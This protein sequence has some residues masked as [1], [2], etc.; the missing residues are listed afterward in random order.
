M[1]NL[2]ENPQGLD[3]DRADALI[4]QEAPTNLEEDLVL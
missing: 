2:N 1:N 3:D 4:Y